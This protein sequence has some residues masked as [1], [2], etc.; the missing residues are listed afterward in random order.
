MTDETQRT[1]E[2]LVVTDKETLKDVLREVLREEGILGTL[3]RKKWDRTYKGDAFWLE[4]RAHVVALLHT[5]VAVA[6][7][8]L[9][10][11]LFFNKAGIVT[12]R[13]WNRAADQHLVPNKPRGADG[14][15]LSTF[16]LGPRTGRYLTVRTWLHCAISRVADRHGR[17]DP[18]LIRKVRVQYLA[19]AACELC[20]G[21]PAAAA[22][23]LVSMEG[24][25]VTNSPVRVTSGPEGSPLDEEERAILRARPEGSPEKEAGD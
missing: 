14:L 24:A 6:Y 25:R 3:K 2:G 9:D 1:L 19:T 10:Q 11:D 13:Q 8:D 20:H 18:A 21:G 15:D 12:D 4:F 22:S 5:N 16:S 7:R 17:R 23:H